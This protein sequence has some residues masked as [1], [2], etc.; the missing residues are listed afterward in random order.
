MCTPYIEEITGNHQF[1]FPC[2]RSD[3]CIR[4]LL[5]TKWEYNDAV[6]QLFIDLKEA[7]DSGEKYCAVF[8]LALTYL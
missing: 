5:Q 8:L 3:I 2:H 6:H 1:E 4:H 7:Y